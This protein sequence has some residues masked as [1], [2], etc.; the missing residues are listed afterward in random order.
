MQ[1][2]LSMWHS[3]NIMIFEGWTLLRCVEGRKRIS[4]YEYWQQK[5]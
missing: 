4:P 2:I 5:Q 1:Y 3:N